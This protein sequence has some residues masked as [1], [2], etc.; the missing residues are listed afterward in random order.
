MPVPY[1]CEAGYS[2][3]GSTVVLTPVNTLA[4]MGTAGACLLGRSCEL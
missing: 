4:L 3:G 1:N 2:V